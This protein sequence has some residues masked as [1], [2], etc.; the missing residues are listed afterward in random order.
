[1]G[2][3]LLLLIDVKGPGAGH[4]HQGLLSGLLVG[5]VEPVA[6]GDRASYSTRPEAIPYSPPKTN[7]TRGFR[8]RGAR[9]RSRYF[10][11]SVSGSAAY[12]IAR[13]VIGWT[14]SG[15]RYNPRALS[16]RMPIIWWTDRP[17]AVASRVRL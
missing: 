15:M 11:G 8:A 3:R 2:Q 16:G 4:V 10:S 6:G 17:R 13:P 5:A 12:P 1:M 9:S 14:P 7:S